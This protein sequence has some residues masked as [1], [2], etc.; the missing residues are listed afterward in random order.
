MDDKPY[1]VKTKSSG[2]FKAAEY[3]SSEELMVRFVLDIYEDKDGDIVEVVKYIPV[4]DLISVEGTEY[5]DPED[6]EG[7]NA[8][9]E[10]E[11][12]PM[13]REK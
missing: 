6:Y 7:E 12:M 11:E 2:N 9:E 13:S 8:E 4:H 10:R 5:A 3:C 1:I